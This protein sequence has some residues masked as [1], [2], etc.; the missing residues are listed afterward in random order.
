MK[1]KFVNQTHIEGILYQHS[2][3]DKITGPNSAHPGTPYITGTID[4]ATDNALTNIV[5]VHFT[6]VTEKTSSGKVNANYALFKNI[7]DQKLGTYMDV[8]D[9]AAKIRIDSAIGLNEFYT[10]RTGSEVFVSA[11]RNEGGF[12]HVVDTLVDDENQRNTFKCDFLITKV[13]HVDQDE[14]RQTPE[15]AIVKGAV[16]NFRNELLPIEL[17]AV[18]PNAINYFESLEC[19]DK[20]PV[21]TQVWGRQI[22]TT[23]SREIRTESAFGDD[24]IRTVQSTRKDF[25]ITG[26]SKVP[27]IWDDESTLTVAE[28]NEM[29]TARNTT[30]ATIKQRSDEWKAS[31]NMTSKNAV[32][33]AAAGG[34]NF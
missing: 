28:L 8:G 15:R 10:D 4:V 18:N 34:F 26:A 33:Q 30:I 23:T 31:Q 6:Y 19:S 22:S 27:Y 14:E 13:T 12:V 16:F 24:D 21:F 1:K 3:E 29:I 2:L 20:E 32:P 7:I 11:K 25:I 5:S 17:V 9:A